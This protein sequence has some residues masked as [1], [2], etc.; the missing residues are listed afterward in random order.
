MPPTRRRNIGRRTRAS[1]RVRLT[2]S[3]Q[4]D[5]Q[6]AQLNLARR[7]PIIHRSRGHLNRLAFQ[8]STVELFLHESV[9]IGMMNKECQYCDAL[10]FKNEP[11]GICCVN[12]KVKLPALNPS[13]EPLLSLALGTSSRSKHFL[14]NIQ[15]Y[16][17]CFQMTSF[18]ATNIIRD[19]YM[20]TF[21]V[22]SKHDHSN[23]DIYVDD[24]YT[25]PVSEI[26]SSTIQ[27]QGQVYHKIGSSLPCPNSNYQFL[28][29]Y[30]VGDSNVEGSRRCDI[31]PNVRREI[32][33]ELQNLLH[34]K[35]ELV[36]LFRRA[37]DRMPSDNH[38]IVIRADEAPAGQHAS[39]EMNFNHVIL[40]FI[41]EIHS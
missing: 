22:I 26:L 28:R 40:C 30:F 36:R 18:G 23:V 27:I 25:N 5:S 2:R 8:Y 19:N 1:A 20:P 15:A 13:L 9:S 10:K 37:L 7:V 24:I 31:S 4:S 17:S 29:I 16:N 39:L 12:G 34:Q 35:N 33:V 41:V 3:Q 11:R 6:R 38:K 14:K 21:K 32:V